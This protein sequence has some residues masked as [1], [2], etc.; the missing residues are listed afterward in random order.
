[1]AGGGVDDLGLELF[2]M[3]PLLAGIAGPRVELE[4]AAMPCGGRCRVSGED[5]TRVMLNLVRNASEAMP[6]GGRLRVTAQYGDGLSFLEPGLVPD[7]YPRT[8]TITVEDSGPGIPKEMLEE[9]F[10][11][12]FSTRRISAGWPDPPHR[13]MGLSIVRE[14]VEAAGGTA[15]ACSTL[16]RGAR[17]ELELP[18]TSGMYEIA[19]TARL[20]ADEAG[21]HA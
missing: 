2:K 5:L 3:R 19:N 6:E 8:V 13:G 15:R 10:L 12:G 18:I 9:I 14:L 4:I 16:G 20:V 1:M 7:G 21:R 11:P 17:F